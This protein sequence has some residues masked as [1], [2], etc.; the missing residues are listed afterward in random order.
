M[1]RD[2]LEIG[3]QV[4]INAG[5]L[6]QLFEVLSRE[7]YKIIGPTIRHAAI[8][9]DELRSFSDLPVGWRD[10]QDAGTYRL[11]KD[12]MESLFG[13]VVGPQSWKKYLHP[14][15]VRLWRAK[16]D[17]GGFHIVEE[18]EEIPQY[19]LVGVRSCDIH[20]IHALDKVFHTEEFS[21]PMYNE[22]RGKAFILAV[23]CTRPGGTCFCVSMNT[24]PEVKSGFDIA[25]TE[26]LDNGHHY[27]IAKAGSEKGT[28]V[29]SG[30]THRKVT[31]QEKRVARRILDESRR[32]MGR[33]LKTSSLEAISSKNFEHP[34]WEKVAERCLTCG[35]CTMVCPTCFCHTIGDANTLNGEHAERW[36]KWDSCFTQD[37]SYIHGGSI[38][39]SEKSRYR[40]WLTHKLVTWEDQFG[41]L[42]CVGCGRC[43]TWCPVGI[44]ITEEAKAILDEPLRPVK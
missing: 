2:D 4:I 7:G 17:G 21:D 35:N 5:G 27:F 14:P 32:Q 33:T 43:I 1:V 8:V 12:D 10:V 40:Q 24:G 29:L 6:Q 28:D 19:A 9:Y 42:G 16:R 38:R 18:K 22:R 31:D 44:D 36:R 30:V 37:F 41:T 39:R 23:N 11:I 13:Y 15:V 26:V 3:D 34:H 25:L 20:A